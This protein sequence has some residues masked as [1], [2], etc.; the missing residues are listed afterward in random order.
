MMTNVVEREGNAA[1]DAETSSI[2]QEGV[3]AR[4]LSTAASLI[5]HLNGA[6]RERK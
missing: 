2:I 3:D 1:A 6:A 5:P 4:I